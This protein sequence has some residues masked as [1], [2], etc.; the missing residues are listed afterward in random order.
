MGR[1]RLDS[2]PTHEVLIEESVAWGGRSSSWR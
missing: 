2:S 1:A